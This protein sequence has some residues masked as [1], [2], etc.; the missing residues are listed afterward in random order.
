MRAFVPEVPDYGTPI[1][2]PHL[3]HH[4]SGLRDYL[5]LQPMAGWPEDMGLTEADFLALVHRQK[6]VTFAP[7]TKH[8]YNNTGYALLSLLVWKV[9][10]LSLREFAAQELFTPHG[11]TD[12]AFRDDH[13]TPIPRR[14]TAY[15]SLASGEFRTRLPGFDV[16][17]DGGLFTTADDLAKWNPTTLDSVLRAQKLSAMMITPGTLVTGDTL[18]YAMGLY[19]HSYRGLPIVRHGGTYGGYRAESTRRRPLLQGQHGN[20]RK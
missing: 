16:V 4:T 11:M 1:T 2:V 12:T 15:E 18:N 17:G 13:A 3:L 6:G 20:L 7:G 9:S 10:G 14:A 19:R 8:L 5:T